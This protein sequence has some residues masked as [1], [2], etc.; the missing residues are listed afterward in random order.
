MFT[1]IPATYIPTMLLIQYVRLE[2]RLMLSF[3]ALLL[4]LAT[5][6][7]GPSKLL[8][9]PDHKLYLIAIGQAC[10]GIFVAS[11]TIPALPEMIVA[12]REKIERIESKR[13]ASKPTMTEDTS[14]D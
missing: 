12:A 3:S 13:R 5:F 1:I 9:L 11:L 2:R 7:N 8:S 14:R 10:S 4:G 6:L